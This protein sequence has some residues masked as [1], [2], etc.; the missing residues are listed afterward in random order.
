MSGTDAREW[1]GGAY[2]HRWGGP[3]FFSDA[4]VWSTRYATWPYVRLRLCND[5]GQL[6][7]ARSGDPEIEFRWPEVREAKR[8]R[9][10]AI[11]FLGEAVRFTF[12][13][14]VQRGLPKQRKRFLFFSGTKR[15]TGEILGIANSKGVKV[16][17][18][19]KNDITV[20]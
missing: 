7:Y 19:A 18:K 5:G 16:D 10:L 15:R 20:P 9:L 8:V 13:E 2:W 17:R 11:P 3:V 4:R 6:L 12:E 14:W 1:T